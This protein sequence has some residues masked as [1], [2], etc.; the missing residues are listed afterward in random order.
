MIFRDSF[1]HADAHPGKFLIPDG[2]HLALLDAGDVGRISGMRK[3]QLEDLVIAAGSRDVD[4]TINV[5]A[6]HGNDQILELTF[7]HPR[8]P[9]D[10]AGIGN[11]MCV[12][13]G[14]RRFPGWGS[15]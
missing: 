3:R 9:A 7:P 13:S 1:F 15:A 6:S 11:A 12:P 5:T 4:T 8:D 10:V 14:I 2:S